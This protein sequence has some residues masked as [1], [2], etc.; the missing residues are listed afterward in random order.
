[1]LQAGDI[2]YGIDNNKIDFVTDDNFNVLITTYVEENY[3]VYDGVVTDLTNSYTK[4][5]KTYYISTESIIYNI[6]RNNEKIAVNGYINVIYN[7]EGKY[8]GWTMLISSDM[9]TGEFAIETYKYSFGESL[10]NAVPFTF[11]WAWKVILIFGQL[12]TG[13]LSITSLAGPITTIDMI[14]TGVQQ[15][16]SFILLLLPLIS[17]NLAVFNLLP[18]P[19]LDGFQMIFV[20]VEWA[21]KKPVKREIINLINN[22][23][24]FALL[25]LVLIVDGIQIFTK[26]F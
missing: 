11:K 14:A 25:G 20:G 17:V 4:E 21:R 3:N 19:A 6:E 9:N 18:I 8:A 26:I 12:L 10:L 15:S 13:Q 5:D 24:L 2:I 7:S 22:I 16:A 23:G 1:M